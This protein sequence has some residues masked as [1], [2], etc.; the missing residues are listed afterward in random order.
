MCRHLENTEFLDWVL[1]KGGWLHPTF[2]WSVRETL[3]RSPIPGP[4]GTLWEILSSSSFADAYARRSFRRTHYLEKLIESPLSPVTRS[5]IFD[6]LTP[7]P[8]IKAKSPQE[9][10]F[11]ASGAFTTGSIQDLVNV[12]MDLTGSLEAHYF[13]EYTLPQ[14]ENREDLLLA[15]AHDLTSLLAETMHWFHLFNLADSTSDQSNIYI[16]SIGNP[17][18]RGSFTDWPHLIEIAWD[19][20]LIANQQD[21]LLTEALLARWR[22]LKFPIFCRFILQAATETSTTQTARAVDLLLADDAHALWSSSTQKEALLFLRKA[23]RLQKKALKRLLRA[24]K[25][26]PQEERPQHVP[27]SDWGRYQHRKIWMRANEVM[28]SGADLDQGDLEWIN[29]LQQTWQF[30]PASTHETEADFYQIHISSNL[31]SRYSQEE[32]DSFD[33]STIIKLLSEDKGNRSGLLQDWRHLVQRNP[34]QGICILSNFADRKEWPPDVWETALFGFRDSTTRS[35][36]RVSWL[37][38]EAPSSLFNAIPRTLSQW[39]REESKSLPTRCRGTFWKLFDKIWPAALQSSPGIENGIAESINHPAGI[40]TQSLIRR[41]AEHKLQRRERIPPVLLPYFDQIASGES[42]S[43]ILARIILAYD[44]N[45]FHA[46]DPE[47]TCKRLI[48][49]FDWQNSSE[50]LHLWEGYLSHPRLD[51]DLFQSLKEYLLQGLQH[52]DSLGGVG[53]NLIRLL[54]FISLEFPDSLTRRENLRFL[55]DLSPK[56]LSEVGEAM[57][58]FLEGGSEQSSQLWRERVENWFSEFWPRGLDRKG[59]EVS[60]SLALASI[61]AKDDFPRAVEVFRD[62]FVRGTDISG[63]LFALDDSE[64]PDRYPDPTLTLLDSLLPY[65]ETQQLYG[66][67]KYLSNLVERIKKSQPEV[68]DDPRHRRVEDLLA[69]LSINS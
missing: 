43:H 28:R 36:F 16:P 17:P 32:M 45:F 12:E 40:L 57:K 18:Q 49:R 65:H 68:V 15:L 30:D 7:V 11:I 8:R 51:L 42:N 37:L 21:E 48:P 58:Y 13:L 4:L 31:Q 6:L 63:V 19:A 67:R 5:E 33:N 1:E 27:D 2:R 10:E 38:K 54:A 69:K 64:Y 56:Q 25:R 29:A 61:A 35:R 14:A 52:L 50:A 47:W 26:G 23:D 60:L 41:M 66:Y 3:K 9:K 34:A 59:P 44:L 62:Y 22:T 46:V 53:T 20:F 39:L 55:R 24:I